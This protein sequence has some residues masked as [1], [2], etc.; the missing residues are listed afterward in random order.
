MQFHLSKLFANQASP[1]DSDRVDKR[2]PDCCNIPLRA[3]NSSSWAI[4]RSSDFYMSRQFELSPE[5][6]KLLQELTIKTKQLGA[7][8]QSDA[9]ML[10]EI[11]KIDLTEDLRKRIKTSDELNSK[12]I[13]EI[14]ILQYKIK[15]LDKRFKPIFSS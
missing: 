6:S 8:I 13:D 2:G 3:K 12:L 11:V 5:V 7:A 15:K 4:S 14:G 10:E 9:A 1:L